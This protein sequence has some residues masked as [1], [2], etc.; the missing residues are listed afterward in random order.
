MDEP[1]GDHTGSITILLRRASQG[2]R[3]AEQSLLQRVYPDLRKIAQSM[4]RG[5]HRP[6]T[7]PGDGTSLVNDACCRLLEREQLTAQ[8]RRHFFFLLGRAMQDELAE[9]AR[10]DLA[11]KRGGD[12][13][14]VSLDPA[15]TEHRPAPDQNLQVREAIEKLQLLDPQGAQVA[16]LR[17]LHDLSLEAT[18]SAMGITVAMVRRHWKYAQAWLRDHFS[19]LHQQGVLPEPDSNHKS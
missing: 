10:S 12:H 15:L 13:R 4:L 17:C 2:D 14:R 7:A 19:G 1:R 3:D 16:Q 8:D 5:Q 11:L 9:Q 18:A 6:T